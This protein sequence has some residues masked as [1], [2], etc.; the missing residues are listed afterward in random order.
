[1]AC[2]P[3]ALLCTLLAGGYS[4]QTNMARFTGTWVVKYQHRNFLVLTLRLD[5]ERM[6][7]KLVR[8]AHFSYDADGDFTKLTREL[9]EV[10]VADSVMRDGQ[11][12]FS[13]GSGSNQGGWEMKLID[14]DHAEL[15]SRDAAGR[16]PPWLLQRASPSA[17]VA[18]DW[19][20]LNPLSPEIAR[21][22]AELTK[23]ADEDQAVRMAIPA[24]LSRMQEVDR[25]HLPAL[26][27]IHRKYGWLKISVA[28]KESA[29]RFWLLVQHQNLELQ[30][31]WMPEMGHLAAKGEA[32]RQNFAL[33]YDRVMTGEGKP[34]RWGTQTHCVA[35][36]A[37]MYPVEDPPNLKARRSA[38]YLTPVSEELNTLTVQCR[39][40]TP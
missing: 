14:R 1:M 30:R 7:G 35:G 21:L 31:S 12:E 29:G 38:L 15:Q 19:P 2:F 13:T 6:S 20:E 11:L 37:V 22:Q 40:S 18:S 10:E 4:T 17:R 28:G 24:S 27:R 36:E 33:L 32:S 26:L 39:N 3:V 23:M 8:P 25:T 16:V 34:Q 9:S 5:H